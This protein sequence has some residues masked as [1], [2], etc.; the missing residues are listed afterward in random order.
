MNINQEL[1]SLSAEQ[2]TWLSPL[3]VLLVGSLLVVCV[4]S[5][6]SKVANA[7]TQWS[8]LLSLVATS[9]VS[10]MLLDTAG[11]HVLFNGMLILDK[12]SY[13]FFIL[14][15]L[16]GAATILMASKYLDLDEM[17][18]PEF[19]VLI[20]FSVIGMML[21]VASADL[22]SLFISL[23]IMSLS[24]YSL[25]AFRRNDRLSNE[26][27]L[28][29]F[30]LGGAAS[31][32]L[33][34]GA[35]LVYG[36]TGSLRIAELLKA[37]TVAQPTVLFSVGS[38]LMVVGFLFKIAAVPFHMWMPDVYEGAPAPVTGFM[39][40]ALKA[41]MFATFI[42]IL[43][44]LGFGKPEW[45]SFQTT[46]YQLL[47]WSA[48]VTMVVGNLAAL[49]QNN[50]K[51]IFAYSSIAHTG[52]LLIG[53]IAALK[54]KTVFA[55]SILYLV[56]YVM[57]SLGAFGVLSLLAKKGDTGL[58]IHDL[59]G[60]SQRRPWLAAGLALFLFSMAGIPPTAGF[61]AK[62][63][64]F[65]AAVE[66]GEVGLVVFA[67]LCSAI[68]VYYYLRVIVFMYMRNPGEQSGWSKPVF[69]AALAIIVAALLTVAMGVS[70]SGLIEATSN[71]A[72]A[73]V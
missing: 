5:L 63:S 29:Y 53:V 71:L 32:I 57:T 48:V 62:Y 23:E 8:S 3:I 36:A 40:A 4:A 72:V 27:G 28:K 14:F 17:N 45:N 68:S 42:R 49:P 1:L 44:Q 47:W 51:R 38:M 19:P 21:L 52:Y 6:F 26:S 60:L 20:L 70:P 61:I 18:H 24:V 64:I 30:I 56:S 43:I 25:V 67:V 22:I 41:A 66:S 55:S 9:V 2:L 13:F 10:Y 58:N 15:N 37:A 54:N 59:S 65:Y 73:Q 69:A 31:A 46:I 16:S 7:L 11:A 50:L 35:A 33:L 12:F 34:Y 39:T